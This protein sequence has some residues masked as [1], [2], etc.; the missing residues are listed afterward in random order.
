MKLNVSFDKTVGKIKAMHGVGQP[1]RLGNSD[2]YMHYLTDAHIPFSRLHDVGGP[3]GGFIYVDIPNIF[4]DFD[5][6][7]NDPASYDFAFTD[8]LITQL[9]AAKCEPIYRLGV[10]IEN[11]SSIKAYR[12]YPP[13]NFAKWARIC[14]HIIRH[15]NEGWADG[16]EY[17][18]VYWEIWNEADGIQRI[19]C[20]P[21]MWLGTP[22]QYYELYEISAKHLKKCFGDK[23]KIGGPAHCGCD[24][25]FTQREKFESGELRPA[26]LTP[27]E[28][29]KPDGIQTHILDFC[30][31]FVE[32]IARTK[33]PLDF[34]SWHSYNHPHE[35][36]YKCGF[37][38]RL[39]ESCGLGDVE[40]QINEWNPDPSIEAR[41]SSRAAANCAAFMMAAQRERNVEIMCYY[42]A[43]IGH[44][45]YG[46]LF[47][48]LTYQPFC[49]YYS[50]KAFGE[51]YALGTEVA[52]DYERDGKL[53]AL[54]A[55]DGEKRG[56][57]IT[58]LGDSR[59]LETNLAGMKVARIDS[60]HMMTDVELDS[61]KFT[62]NRYET[63]YIYN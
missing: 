58:N 51:L 36:E 22:E 12:I 6:D 29:G 24:V 37:I 3:Y 48:P 45:V 30:I 46:G 44:S 8:I 55:T 34:Y 56:V 61:A 49:T 32:H 33:T 13:K 41:G 5:A 50:F 1:P 16:F 35:L 10:T 15:Y 63:V 53:W 54:A 31:G 20:T 4:R 7:E 17:G 40:Q 11:S 27:L 47:N 42:D 21:E 57:L 26:D 28:P 59:E 39:L 2:A 23:I 19:S 52:V 9:K 43:R 62:L 14:E 18:I 25:I 60:E 38:N